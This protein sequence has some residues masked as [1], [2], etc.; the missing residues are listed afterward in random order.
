MEFETISIDIISIY[1][2][3]VQMADY[4]IAMIVVSQNRYVH[5]FNTKTF[6]EGEAT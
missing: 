6:T 3:S 2:S 5:I 4:F 1:F